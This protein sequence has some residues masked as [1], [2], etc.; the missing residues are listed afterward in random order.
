MSFHGGY[1]EVILFDFWNTQNSVARNKP[2]F[3]LCSFLIISFLINLYFS[4]VHSLMRSL[5]HNGC[6]V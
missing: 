5:I 6:F 3:M 1:D 2:C 4:S